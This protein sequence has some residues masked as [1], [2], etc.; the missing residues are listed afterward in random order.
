MNLRIAFAILAMAL[1][2]HSF[3]ADEVFK[4]Y[5]QLVNASHGL[6]GTCKIVFRPGEHR[7]QTKDST[8][9]WSVPLG[10]EAKVS[11]KYVSGNFARG[12]ISFSTA[13][14]VDFEFRKKKSTFLLKRLEYRS[15]GNVRIWHFDPGQSAG[16]LDRHLG[17]CQNPRALF[18]GKPFKPLAEKL[19][20]PSMIDRIYFMPEP[21]EDR[22]TVVLKDQAEIRFP[23]RDQISV[24]SPNSQFSF[25]KFSFSPSRRKISGEF[26]DLQFVAYSG[27]IHGGETELTLANNLS[28]EF[29]KIAFSESGKRVDLTS[30]S[31]NGRLGP[32]TIALAVHD[33]DKAF[34]KTEQIFDDRFSSID[35]KDLSYAITETNAGTL[36]F[37]IGILDLQISSGKLTIAGRQSIC[38]G[39]STAKLNVVSALWGAGGRPK[40]VGRLN[41]LVGTIAPLNSSSAAGR[42]RLNSHS[43][44]FLG[45]GVVEAQELS[46]DTLTDFPISG[47]FEKLEST[48]LA[49]ST[50]I[51]PDEVSL[52]S[53][54]KGSFIATS[55]SAPF[56][57]GPEEIFPRSDKFFIEEFP[58]EKGSQ[59]KMGA[60]GDVIFSGGLVVA[61]LKTSPKDSILGSIDVDAGISGGILRPN[62]GSQLFL[63]GGGLRA[64]SLVIDS[65]AGVTGVIENLQ[66]QFGASLLEVPDV[67]VVATAGTGTMD[68]T[69]GDRP[70]SISAD[71]TD[72]IG[73]L[74][75]QCNVSYVTGKDASNITLRD[76]RMD[77]PLM[78]EKGADL[79]GSRISISG[80]VKYFLEGV[81]DAQVHLSLSEGFLTSYYDPFGVRQVLPRSSELG[82]VGSV[83]LE[84]R[85]LSVPFVTA[86]KIERT[87]PVQVGP[88]GVKVDEGTIF[89]LRLNASLSSAASFQ[90]IQLRYFRGGL[91]PANDAV[92]STSAKADVNLNV[93][94]G[95][96]EYKNRNTF[97]EATGRKKPLQ[98]GFRTVIR[99]VLIG[100]SVANGLFPSFGTPAA[101]RLLPSFGLGS[102]MP[103]VSSGFSDA[104]SGAVDFFTNPVGSVVDR[105]NPFSSGK[106]SA[107]NLLPGIASMA[108]A[109]E[110][111]LYA[112]PGEYKA[113]GVMSI[114]FEQSGQ[115]L[116]IS[117]VKR[118]SRIGVEADG[119]FE[120]W[121]QGMQNLLGSHPL[122]DIVQRVAN[123][124][125]VPSNLAT[126]LLL[127]WII[128]SAA[129]VGI[130]IYL[131]K[132][133]PLI[134]PISGRE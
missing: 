2:C 129:N 106:S 58:I 127:D 102:V 34:L 126:E 117:S 101:T 44:F 110:F 22:E 112:V 132:M 87:P 124:G 16:E 57:Y 77:L 84:A 38:L 67:A 93:E 25:K 65:E 46:L 31:M 43:N 39:R 116:S 37:G 21:G 12:E 85:K 60:F 18:L 1:S 83:Q 9:T 19:A 3:G 5:E 29:K 41:G 130:D 61:T 114:S 10:A 90:P 98:E 92:T 55:D 68:S 26:F 119:G 121:A 50:L 113:S 96:G 53:S 51:T 133:K 11:Y 82:L 15:L 107:P 81:A 70:L 122:Q 45:A 78:F 118:G 69:N 91:V 75:I 6:E 30:G 71:G 131:R 42:L 72:L 89:P 79:S 40:V 105:L 115:T 94:P 24:K 14:P 100:T 95:I 48:L 35:V 28:C 59:A 23:G 63:S 56:T 74:R 7:T 73:G 27:R 99:P 54:S 32:S 128:E 108:L 88:I 125:N 52:T 86:D 64:K 76:G 123:L 66:V 120:I 8:L 109:S 62:P 20:P 49:N 97:T 36:G 4:F 103:S 134:I 13:I 111:H 33:D 47:S 17:F 104:V 80:N